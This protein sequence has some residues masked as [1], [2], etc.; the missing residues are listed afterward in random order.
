MNDFFSSE[1]Q[2]TIEKD[3]GRIIKCLKATDAEYKGCGEAYITTIRQ[4]RIKG[5]I[6][7][8]KATLNLVCIHGCVNF[9]LINPKSLQ[10]YAVKIT[11]K[12]PTRLTIYPKTW[13]GFSN[14]SNFESKI[15]SIMDVEHSDVEVRK[16]KLSQFPLDLF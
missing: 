6:Y 13:F 14:K 1:K 4:N 2:K 3:D 16:A 8:E 11:D 12:F 9:V 5:W 15:L 7:H 10:Q